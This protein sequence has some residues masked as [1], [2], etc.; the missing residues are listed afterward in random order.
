MSIKSIAAKLFA[1]YIYN[2]TQAW[3]ISRVARQQ[4]VFNQ[5]IQEARTA[6]GKDHHLIRLKPFATL[7]SSYT[8]L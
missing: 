4:A 6:F 2:K 1:N 7:K 8:R 5:L 3:V